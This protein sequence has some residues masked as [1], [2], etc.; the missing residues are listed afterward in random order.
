MTFITTKQV[1]SEMIKERMVDFQKRGGVPEIL[2]P[3]RT[4]ENYVRGTHGFRSGRTG[5][6]EVK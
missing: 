2:P 1:T 6:F 3:S 5:W 4:Q